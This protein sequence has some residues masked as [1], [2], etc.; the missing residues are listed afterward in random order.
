MKTLKV[1]L[2]LIIYVYR[3][4]N[5]YFKFEFHNLFYMYVFYPNLSYYS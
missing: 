2:K 5:Y 4:L 1:N 3:N